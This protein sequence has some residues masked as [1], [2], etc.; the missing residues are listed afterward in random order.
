[1]VTRS[2]SAQVTMY[3]YPG[4]VTHWYF[5]TLWLMLLFW[6]ELQS[7]ALAASV[8]FHFI[9]TLNNNIIY[10]IT[11]LPLLP[12]GSW[13]S[14]EEA[15]LR[16]ILH[17]W[18]AVWTLDVHMTEYTTRDVET[19][20]CQDGTDQSPSAA[21][22]S[23]SASPFVTGYM[24][25]SWVFMLHEKQPTGLWSGTHGWTSS[26]A[27]PASCCPFVR[28]ERE[29]TPTV[30]RGENRDVKAADA[31][32]QQEKNR[33]KPRRWNGTAEERWRER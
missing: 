4:L 9:D 27:A 5:P 33:K 1:M 30:Q 16:Y 13:D 17:V 29:A 21:E 15:A 25:H 24:W 6:M 19:S 31:R 23:V 28:R 11:A 8:P 32:V 3:W 2:G 7:S 14:A 26:A 22:P 12:D 20:P 18:S 10:I